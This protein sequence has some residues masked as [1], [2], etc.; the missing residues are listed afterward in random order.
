M[1]RV[2]W[3]TN[4]FIYLFENNAEWS[5]RVVEFRQRMRTRRDELLTSWLTV[6]EALTKPK[7]AGNAILEK[8]YLNFFL[9]GSVELVAFEAEAA[10]RYAEIR[11]RERVRPADAI[12]LACA[13]AAGTDL[14][15]TNDSRLSGLVVSGVTFITGIGR[16]PY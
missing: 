4:L 16:I 5:P 1:A 11:S 13:A 8:S 2:F 6:G 9:S 10:K 12:Q 15:V 3:D 7:E 14:F